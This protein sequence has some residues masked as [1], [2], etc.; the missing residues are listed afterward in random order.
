MTDAGVSVVVLLVTVEMVEFELTT[1]LEVI[2]NVLEEEMDVGFVVV[3][4]LARVDVALVVKA[5]VGFVVRV[6]LVEVVL[7]VD[8]IAAL[9]EIKM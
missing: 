1:E 3:V 7:L 2:F 6:D 8:E 5:D 4:V 9:V